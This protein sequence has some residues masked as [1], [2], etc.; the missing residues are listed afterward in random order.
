MFKVGKNA[1]EDLD[2]G[3]SLMYIVGWWD[4]NHML[5]LTHYLSLIIYGW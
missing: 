5:K 1:L 3:G 4:L 2:L